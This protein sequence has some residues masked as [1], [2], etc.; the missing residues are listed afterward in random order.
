VV[1]DEEL[2]G[3]ASTARIATPSP[4]FLQAVFRFALSTPT[5]SIGTTSQSDRALCA[6]TQEFDGG[7]RAQFDLGVHVDVGARLQRRGD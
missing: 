5:A 1:V 2:A 6:T 3:E 4:P 7:G